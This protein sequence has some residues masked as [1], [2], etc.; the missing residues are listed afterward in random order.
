VQCA[1]VLVERLQRWGWFIYRERGGGGG[2]GW[3]RASWLE[4]SWWWGVLSGGCPGGYDRRGRA[5][6]WGTCVRAEPMETNA[7]EVQLGPAPRAATWEDGNGMDRTRH[8]LSVCP[9]AARRR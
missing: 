1:M 4:M 9:R 5:E 3:G 2:L 8:C 7:L 6:E